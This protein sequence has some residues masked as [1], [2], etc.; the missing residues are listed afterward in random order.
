MK[1]VTT[2]AVALLAAA[3][4]ALPAAAQ[5]DGQVVYGSDDRIDLYQTTDP[6]LRA[7]ADSTVALM[8][9]SNV[10]AGG[11]VCKLTTEPY[12]TGMGLCKDEPFYE[13]ETAAFCS[14]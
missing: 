11:S 9:A 6:K 10:K 14:G 12:G 2:F 13:Q 8:Q 5:V 3:R 1:T 4:L 7:L